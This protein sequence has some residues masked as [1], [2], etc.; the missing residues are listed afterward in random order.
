MSGL[1]EVVV[2]RPLLTVPLGGRARFILA[3]GEA[4]LEALEDAS[5]AVDT[6]M[7]G[8]G[9][10]LLEADLLPYTAERYVAKS[11]PPSFATGMGVDTVTVRLVPRHG[12]RGLGD[13]LGRTDILN[14]RR[15]IL[16][17][18]RMTLTSLLDNLV[19]GHVTGSRWRALDLTRDVNALDGLWL[20]GGFPK[21]LP[22]GW[23]VEK[24]VLPGLERAVELAPGSAAVRVML[25]EAQLRFGLPQQC[26]DSCNEALRLQPELRRAN[27]LRGLALWRLQHLALAEVD[28]DVSLKPG[29]YGPMQDETAR[30]LRAR[31]GLR[32]LLGNMTGMCADMHQACAAGDCEGLRT[33]RREGRC[34]EAGQ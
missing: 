16:H 25:A 12:S 3:R 30:R 29:P 5:A 4:L 19:D 2:R 9:R 10:H 32:L 34:Q 17:E 18:T 23:L 31:G 20:V 24:R 28:F 1:P 13:T 14:I 8:M 26:V 11:E 33:M 27:Y 21:S 6:N 22:G 15:L 7:K